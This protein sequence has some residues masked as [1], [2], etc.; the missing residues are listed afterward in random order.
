MFGNIFGCH[1]LGELLL[2]SSELRPE[3]LLNILQY[4]G[5]PPTAK[6][7]PALKVSSAEAERPSSM[8]NQ[9]GEQSLNL[10]NILFPS[11]ACLGRL[12]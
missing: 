4:T 6:N 11:S 9:P 3:M 12:F 8:A 2:A 5:Q 7:D 1:S 10:V